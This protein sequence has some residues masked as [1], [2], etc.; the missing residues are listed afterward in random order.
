MKKTILALA[1]VAAAVAAQ[2]KGGGFGAYV[3]GFGM[4]LNSSTV[5]F[6]DI[7]RVDSAVVKPKTGFLAHRDN[8]SAQLAAHLAAQGV[9]NP[10]CATFFSVERGKVEKEYMK[11]RRK[12]AKAG[13]HEIK[14]VDSTAFKYA[15][16]PVDAPGAGGK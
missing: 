6:T 16:A 13:S 8:Y 2:A 14:V 3:F 15:H 7:Q 5:Y 4:P 1:A 11:M 12:Y 10:T 9:A